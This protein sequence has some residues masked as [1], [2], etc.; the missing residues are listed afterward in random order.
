VLDIKKN[1][2]E[3]VV[4]HCHR[5]PRE[6]VVSLGLL[7]F[8]SVKTQHWGP[9]VSGHGG[10]D[11]WMALVILVVF[12]SL[13]GSVI[14]CGHSTQRGP[15]TSSPVVLSHLWGA[16]VTPCITA[17]SRFTYS[18]QKVSAVLF[19]S[20]CPLPCKSFLTKGSLNARIDSWLGV[21]NIRTQQQC[22][23]F[24]KQFEGFKVFLA[25][26]AQCSQALDLCF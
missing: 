11:W 14:L 15:S 2:F 25:S 24:S 7:V 12:S 20:R 26:P 5:L 10:M 4:I 6:V 18:K 21:Q 16:K 22:W 3:R 13:I 1:F 19:T 8:S 17:A 23:D 9:R